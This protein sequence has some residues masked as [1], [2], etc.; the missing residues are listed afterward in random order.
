MQYAN[1]KKKIE[2]LNKIVNFLYKIRYFIIG[3][4]VLSTATYISVNLAIG[5]GTTII[6]NSG[7]SVEY[8][9]D[10]TFGAK[11][12]L[13]TANIEYSISNEDNWKK[14]KPK[15]VG[16]Y[17]ARSYSYNGWGNKTNGTTF[18]FSIVP[19]KIKIYV[20]QNELTY[21]DKINF[22]YDNL[23]FSDRLQN[24]EFSFGKKYDEENP[25]N[26][27]DVFTTSLNIIPSSFT[28][29]DANDNNN[30]ASYS[31]IFE[32]KNISIKKRNLSIK[33]NA[34]K[35]EYD[36]NELLGND[37]SIINGSLAKDDNIELSDISKIK[38][39][40]EVKIKTKIN[41]FDKNHANRT[42][43]YNINEETN[44][45]TITKRALKI[46]TSNAT[47]VYDGNPI[48]AEEFSYDIIQGALLDNAT[49]EVKF[50]NIGKYKAGKFKNTITYKIY[51][52]NTKEDLESFYNFSCEVGNLEIEKRPISISSYSETKK[53]D[54][55]SINGNYM[56]VEG[57][58]A[59]GDSFKLCDELPVIINPKKINYRPNLKIF[60]NKEEDVSDSYEITTT[61]GTLE[62]VKRELVIRVNP[63]EKMYDG[64]AI[65]E[66]ELS[67]TI[68]GDGLSPNHKLSVTYNLL[69]TDCFKAGT[70][71]NTISFSV[72]DEN[73]NYLEP[74]DFYNVEIITSSV[75]INKRTGL[76]IST[77]NLE[78]IYDNQEHS[79]PGFTAVGLAESDEI[80]ILD[81]YKAIKNVGVKKNDFRYSIINKKFNE[82][83][84]ESYENINENF[85]DLAVSKRT[86]K[87]RTNSINKVYDGSE[88]T[89][90]D[91]TYE[92]DG[93]SD[94]ASSLDFNVE[95]DALKKGIEEIVGVE[96]INS[97]SLKVLDKNGNEADEN[98]VKYISNFNVLYEY[99]TIN[100]E[101]A[102]LNVKT[103][104][105]DLTYDSNNHQYSDG[106]F[107]INGLVGNDV[108]EIESNPK[109]NVG[110][111][112]NDFS[113]KIYNGNNA[114]RKEVTN[115]YN[116]NYD[117][118][119]L[120][121]NKRTLTIDLTNVGGIYTFSNTPYSFDLSSAQIDNLAPNDSIN[122][123][124]KNESEIKYVGTY[125]FDN[126]YELKI[127]N[128]KGNDVTSNY[129]IVYIINSPKIIINKFDVNIVCSSQTD[130][131][132]G[133]IHSYYYYSRNNNLP[134][135][136]TLSNN[137]VYGPD[138]TDTPKNINVNDFIISD[139]NTNKN[140]TSNFNLIF[141]GT[142]STFSIYRKK[143]T[144][145]V[146]EA[147]IKEFDGNDL[148]KA[149]IEV[150]DGSLAYDDVL[151]LTYPYH[152]GN[153]AVCKNE[154][155]EFDKN[156]IEIK[157]SKNENKTN[158][159]DITLVQSGTYTI[160]S[161]LITLTLPENQYKFVY[162]GETHSYTRNY[163]ISSKS[164]LAPTDHIEFIDYN[165]V[166]VKNVSDSGTKVN[167]LD[168]NKIKII[169]ESG[170]DHTSNYGISVESDF[171]YEI[172]K[173]NIE[174]VSNDIDKI[175]D[176]IPLS[177][178]QFSISTSKGGPNEGLLKNHEIRV[179]YDK[180]N[181]VNP[182]N[183]ENTFEAR[184]VDK[185]TNEDV[186]EN[187]NI[188]NTSGTISIK[189]LNI[190]LSIFSYSYTYGENSIDISL[191]NEEME[192]TDKSNFVRYKNKNDYTKAQK[193]GIK[194]FANFESLDFSSLNAAGD[195]SSNISYRVEQ[196]NVDITNL[197]YVVLKHD[198]DYIELK[199]KK[200][201]LV[202]ETE[203]YTDFG[204]EITYIEG[205]PLSEMIT[206]NS[207]SDISAFK[208]SGCTI[209]FGDETYSEAK[210]D[211]KSLP[212]LEE[213][214]FYDESYYTNFI[215]S[216]RILDK[217]GKDVTSNFD[218]KFIVHPVTIVD[219]GN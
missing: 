83:V 185:N 193:I 172:S 65:N 51:D 24:L 215:N 62:I 194:I 202:F 184:I 121:I 99:G 196:N 115:C 106:I 78:A 1:Y 59:S 72:F 89:D 136:C 94:L 86:I 213:P 179:T 176:G 203:D 104:D 112:I 124:I 177:D 54:N 20:S 111:Y 162:D 53:Y 6:E 56:L 17:T 75:V 27:K 170:E 178:K 167:H 97:L 34:L 145:A 10:Y 47:K 120:N 61:N 58:L 7:E 101:K 49:L 29:L 22:T 157:N 92:I 187:Y 8:G 84:T 156:L 217:N 60:N 113:L 109:I 165:D 16:S 55:E 151:T 90:S 26:E 37:Y 123:I 211:Y 138:V 73:N 91:I 133:N 191:T 103:K 207:D 21:G 38:D 119:K 118:G 114:L 19:K 76:G 105:I 102:T 205:I 71:D 212:N 41:I 154:P 2:V 181:L 166:E 40:G 107:S 117:F 161:I 146:K 96:Q 198:K 201:K 25:F 214:G 116:I 31:P 171:T 39:I 79:N 30:S 130:E 134:E 128:S 163:S 28:V 18:N 74:F 57:E 206:I 204:N 95:K 131:Y 143:I 100:I 197:G 160:A 77:N 127:V 68:E 125:N 152:V 66:N 80:N 98:G 216:I 174:I 195:Y 159:Y 164:K 189:L 33:F 4:I 70:Y 13:N 175:Y 82:D 12:N 87:L 153:S 5:S 3:A 88:L 190:D 85:G 168:V 69:F 35:K 48:N 43:F 180:V 142:D 150:A 140:L 173:R 36:E 137:S 135:N 169:G 148:V 11:S 209:Y 14:E 44:N 218:I 67:Y 32:E 23:A 208:K 46:K 141:E 93:I 147:N 110:T 158:N 199:I 63:F 186:T 129:D 132:D 45:L 210:D 200:C 52:K 9:T 81:E 139:T 183:Y 108:Y 50:D 182:G 219:D 122:W 15:N 188:T 155:F 144:I 149:N 64:K 192:V 42:Y 126:Y